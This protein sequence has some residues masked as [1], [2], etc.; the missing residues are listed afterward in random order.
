MTNNALEAGA[1]LWA[2]RRPCGYDTTYGNLSIAF[3]GATSSARALGRIADRL[4]ARRIDGML[5]KAGGQV[6]WNDA[7]IE[8]L[9]SEYRSA[10]MAQREAE[11]LTLPHGADR[12]LTPEQVSAVLD[13]DPHLWRLYIAPHCDHLIHTEPR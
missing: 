12:T 13:D 6:E 10:R 1:E 2:C 3:S 4:H 11:G 8:A 5:T 7:N 9:S